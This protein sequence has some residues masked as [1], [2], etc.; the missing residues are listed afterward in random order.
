ME[1]DFEI[2]RIFGFDPLLFFKHI[3]IND[4]VYLVRF[5]FASEASVN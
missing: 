3:L 4:G 2:L 5:D 1:P